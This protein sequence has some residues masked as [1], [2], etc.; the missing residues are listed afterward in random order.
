M[1][2]GI[3]MLQD[4]GYPIEDIRE[5]VARLDARREA[6]APDSEPAEKREEPETAGEAKQREE[7]DD[8]PTGE[9]PSHRSKAA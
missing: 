2:T 6:N 8:P 9:A 4:A 5:E 3:R 1:E 7:G